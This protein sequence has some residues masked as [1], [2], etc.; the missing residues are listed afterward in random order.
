MLKGHIIASNLRKYVYF[1]INRFVDSVVFPF[2]KSPFDK[3]CFLKD[4]NKI[5]GR[6]LV[7]YTFLVNNFH[8]DV[9]V[10]NF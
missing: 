7:K 2:S 3:L 5:Y 9:I 8:N 1:F 4:I 6:F 10:C